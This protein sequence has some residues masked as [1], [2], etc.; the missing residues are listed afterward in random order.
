MIAAGRRRVV[1]AMLP[2]LLVGGGAAR[3]A[4]PPPIG[5]NVESCPSPW[6]REIRGALAVELGDERLAGP[7]GDERPTASGDRVHVR[8]DAQRVQ[9]RARDADSPATLERTLAVGDLP[10]ATAPRVVALAAVELL[11]RLRSGAASAARGVAQRPVA[12]C[13]PRPR[14]TAACR[15]PPA[16]CTGRSS[17]RRGIQAWGGALDARR[18]SQSGRWS[19]GLG[20]GDRGRRPV[21][22]HRPDLGAPRLGARERWECGSRSRAIGSRWPSTLGGRA[23]AAR[24]SG[25]AG[26]PGV[27]ASTVVRPWAGPVAAVTAQVGL[28][29]FCAAIAVEVGW[30]AVSA[31]GLVDDGPALAAHGPWLAIGLGVGI[32]R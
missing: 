18:A 12:C 5:V 14:A 17:L 4:G 30:A 15:S 7:R 21:D 19:V 2:A 29:S 28:S 20:F 22:A 3:A 31:S 1:V 23:G 24:L 10:A 13:R 6:D 25:H 11:R 16:A 9:V 26:D 8:C 32:R 27:V